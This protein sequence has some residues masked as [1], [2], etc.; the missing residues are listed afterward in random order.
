MLDQFELA[1]WQKL[2]NKELRAFLKSL[3][4][5]DTDIGGNNHESLVASIE[6]F[7]AHCRF[8]LKHFSPNPKTPPALDE[9]KSR[10]PVPTMAALDDAVAPKLDT[11]PAEV[12][13]AIQDVVVRDGTP[14][15]QADTIQQQPEPAKEEEL[16]PG[17]HDAQWYSSPTEKAG[18]EGGLR[19]V[20]YECKTTLQ[21]VS[22]HQSSRD[23]ALQ[24]NSVLESQCRTHRSD[25]PLSG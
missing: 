17:L 8:A 19:S 11:K 5:Q 16:G 7:L 4:L 6:T 10:D 15:P 12:N 23:L 24:S 18:G 1:N 2:T 14:P 21:T 9:A 25:N 20:F 22:S 13:M 3:D